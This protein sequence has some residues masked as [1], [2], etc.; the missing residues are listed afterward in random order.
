MINQNWKN[1]CFEN[2]HDITRFPCQGFHCGLRS[3][4]YS[5]MQTLTTHANVSN[6]VKNGPISLQQV[7][8]ERY[9]LDPSIQVLLETL[10]FVFYVI[11]FY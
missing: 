1:A 3:D 7:R 11:L 5:T 6:A 9:V 8:Q 10:I 4:K 2:R